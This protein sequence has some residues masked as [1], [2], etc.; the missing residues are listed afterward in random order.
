MLLSLF[1]QPNAA[2]YTAEATQEH[3]KKEYDTVKRNAFLFHHL[4][5]QRLHFD[6]F[7]FFLLFGFLLAFPGPFAVVIVIRSRLIGVSAINFESLAELFA[8]VDVL[9]S[10][11][12]DFHAFLFVPGLPHEGGERVKDGRLGRPVV[13]IFALLAET[14]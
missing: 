2:S 3:H 1:A 5:C 13:S 8:Q 6:Y 9:F 14:H 11:Y 12:F 4:L 7:F 10:S